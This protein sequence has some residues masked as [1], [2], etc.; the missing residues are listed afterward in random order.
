MADRA[1]L[2]GLPAVPTVQGVQ[3]YKRYANTFGDVRGVSISGHRH[4]STGCFGCTIGLAP[5]LGIVGY[6]S[7]TNASGQRQSDDAQKTDALHTAAS[8]A[9][10]VAG[11]LDE[12][13]LLNALLPP[14]TG[15]ALKGVA[16]ASQALKQGYNL[17]DV[18]KNVGPNT[19]NVIKGILSLF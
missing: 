7:I 13:P 10:D 6:G 5:F 12:H 14:G 9:S 18:A 19:A 1:R 16:F 8:V 15:M 2:T 11:M 3:L 17:N 4:P